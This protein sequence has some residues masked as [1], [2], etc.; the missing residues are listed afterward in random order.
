MSLQLDIQEVL[1]LGLQDARSESLLALR[2]AM[3]ACKDWLG[4]GPHIQACLVDQASGERVDLGFCTESALLE[5]HAGPRFQAMGP[6]DLDTE[7]KAAAQKKVKDLLQPRVGACL[8]H[9]VKEPLARFVAT[10]QKAHNF[11]KGML[12][13]GFEGLRKMSLEDLKAVAASD[14]DTDY[15]AVS[16]RLLASQEKGKVDG[17]NRWLSFQV[18][19]AKVAIA[20][21]DRAEADGAGLQLLQP[22]DSILLALP[23]LHKTRELCSMFVEAQTA[24]LALDSLRAVKLHGLDVDLDFAEMVSNASKVVQQL[25]EWALKAWRAGVDGEMDQLYRHCPGQS[26]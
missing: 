17:M 7:V 22:K 10:F 18:A 15:A 9:M 21:A 12:T 26:A 1:G 2:D 8:Q 23:Q 3:Q 16:N 6:L 14:F 24:A 19:L 5:L 25:L 20:M 11:Y 13:G 4:L